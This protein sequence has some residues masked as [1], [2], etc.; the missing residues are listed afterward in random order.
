[1][2]HAHLDWL[3]ILSIQNEILGEVNQQNSLNVILSKLT[4]RLDELGSGH[5]AT[6][7]LNSPDGLWPTAGRSIPSE[8]VK[9]ISPLLPGPTQGSCG[10]AAFR[11]ETVIVENI[12]EDPL[13]AAFK[14]NQPTHGFMACWSQP[15]L[16]EGRLVA[17][18][19]IYFKEPRPPS[20][21]EIEVIKSLAISVA[22]IIERKKNDEKIKKLQLDLTELSFLDGLTDISNRRMFDHTFEKEWMRAQRNQSEL[23]LIMIDIDFFKKYNDHYGHQQG[24]DCLRQVAQALNTVTHRSIDL[25]ARY[26]GEEFIILIP[27][28]GAEHVIKIAER[29][30]RAVMH[31]QIPH[32]GSDICNVITI[33][34]GVCNVIPAANTPPSSLVV[35]VDN[36]LYVA[37]GNG[38]NR[39]EHS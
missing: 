22:I 2:I 4:D 12:L 13:W 29:C 32:V 24:D 31:L 15:V 16:L 6:I 1:M 36:F 38:R 34:A 30:R 28:T 26:G 8:W 18:F 23:S 3:K 5:A 27:E 11:K 20:E 33:S 37:K 25:V 9:L 21:N 7:L 39:I 17:T 10:T 19:A 35:A 14:D